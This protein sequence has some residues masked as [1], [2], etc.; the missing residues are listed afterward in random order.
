MPGLFVQNAGPLVKCCTEHCS[1][2]DERCTY[3][4]IPGMSSTVLR[5]RFLLFHSEMEL[6]KPHINCRL[7][8]F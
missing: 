8:M 5:K 2:H 4:C 6:F 3:L 1:N 7:Q